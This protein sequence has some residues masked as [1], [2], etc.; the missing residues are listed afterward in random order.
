MADAISD[1]HE[2]DTSGLSALSKILR[3]MSVRESEEYLE[4][5]NFFEHK[6]YEEVFK[7]DLANQCSNF[8]FMRT[9]LGT[10]H[11]KGVSHT[12]NSEE[13]QKICALV[14]DYRL[15][16]NTEHASPLLK[17]LLSRSDFNVSYLMKVEPMSI[18][19]EHQ[20]EWRMTAAGAFA[21]SCWCSGYGH[22]GRLPEDDE[23]KLCYSQSRTVMDAAAAKAY[24]YMRAKANMKEFEEHQ[25]VFSMI[26]EYPGYQLAGPVDSKLT[27]LYAE[28]TKPC[29]RGRPG[30]FK[31]FKKDTS[32]QVL[33]FMGV[34]EHAIDFMSPQNADFLLIWAHHG[35]GMRNWACDKMLA[36]SEKKR[37]STQLQLSANQSLAK[38]QKVMG[39]P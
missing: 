13:A 12:R 7:D 11:F 37:T 31:Q 26:F 36:M 16:E 6:D 38:R 32:E 30:R 1:Y 17:I 24:E 8:A 15:F 21:M 14:S 29:G 10:M 25:S 19:S 34:D 23:A 35:R 2:Y 20:A 22:P 9:Y 3:K 4:S 33:K 28:S 5:A 18:L 39:Q 27:K